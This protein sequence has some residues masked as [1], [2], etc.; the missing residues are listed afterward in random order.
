M[1]DGAVYVRS[2]SGRN[3]V[4]YLD[5]ISREWRHPWHAESFFDEGAW[6]VKILPGFVNGEAALTGTGEKDDPET[7]DREDLVALTELPAIKIPVDAYTRPKKAS[8]FFKRKGVIDPPKDPEVAL[9]GAGGVVLTMP[10]E[11]EVSPDAR[12]LLQA[13]V[14]LTQARATQKMEVSIPGN[15]VQG[16]LVN[17]TIV[18]D[19]TA[20]SRFGNRPRVMIAKDVPKPST[21]SL[22]D[23]LGGSVNDET[24]DNLMLS[25]LYFVSPAGVTDAKEPDAT[26]DP[27]VKHEVFWNLNYA[28]RNKP[29]INLPGFALDPFTAAFVGRYTFAPAGAIGAL[30]E[31][32]A[33]A[34]AAT[35]NDASN[36]GRFWTV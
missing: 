18:W 12:M 7:D 8:E 1:S 21:P 27:Y 32:L 29:P 28:A 22:L 9:G 20:L 24:F 6:K 14:Y 5:K 36:R 15:L 11:E 2:C 3:A 17:Y 34:L 26:W 25:T 13:V 31:I 16:D 30:N 4:Y 19:T 33:R 23:I 35:F 10:F